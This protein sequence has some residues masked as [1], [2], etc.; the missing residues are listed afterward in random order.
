MIEGYMIQRKWI[1]IK[2][3]MM[4]GRRDGG[5]RLDRR[6]ETSSFRGE[7]ERANNIN[8][9]EGECANNIHVVKGERANN[10]FYF[11]KEDFSQ[12]GLG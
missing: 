5:D 9:K 11:I 12:R 7:G 6:G 10:I 2:R 1:M 8:I 4:R 3:I